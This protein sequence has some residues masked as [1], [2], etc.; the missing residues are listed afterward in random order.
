MA[1]LDSSE[2]E[3]RKQQI[4]D[5]WAYRHLDHVPI[6]LTVRYNPWGY[7]IQDQ[8]R[9]AEKQL[10]VQVAS[11]ERT[12]TVVPDDVIPVLQ[13]SVASGNEIAA[14]IGGELY[15]GENPDQP[16]AIRTKVVSSVTDLDKLRPIDRGESSI[17]DS[18]LERISFFARQAEWP[19]ALNLC[20]PTDTAHSISDGTWF[21]SAM[22]MNPE[23]IDRLYR[24]VVTATLDLVGLAVRAA[25]GQDRVTELGARIW[26][27]EG[28]LGYVSDDVAT[29]ISPVHFERFNR[30]VNDRIFKRYGPG[31]LHVCGPHPSAHLYLGGRYPPGAI[32]A[33]WRYTAE[34]LS[35]IR[36][37]LAGKAVLYLELTDYE[38]WRDRD[39]SPLVARYQQAVDCLAPSTVV[40]AYLEV[41]DE[42][43]AAALYA[44]LRTISERFA[45]RMGGQQTEMED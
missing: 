40:V 24:G 28:R 23:S 2:L 33:S 45:A 19:L 42:V 12:L 11:I 17:V 26:C 31:I 14:A 25:G 5:M 1:V 7:S 39:F 13:P 20:G 4:R 43:D 41:G 16:P 44:Q 32:T 18:W 36:K 35:R 27:P 38:I 8:Y 15:W 29:A 22:A 21:Y 3:R 9:S 30:P 37:A 10:A 6:W 34:H